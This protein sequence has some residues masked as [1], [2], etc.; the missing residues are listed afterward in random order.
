MME[1]NDNKDVIQ[2]EKNKLHIKY[3][4]AIAS[5]ISIG[6]IVLSLCNKDIFVA[7]VSFASTITSIV[8]S[9]IAIWMSISSERT[10][11][12]IK[13]KIWESTERLAKTTENVEI[14]NDRNESIMNTQLH[15]LND[16]KE[17]LEAIIHSVDTVGEQ[18]TI[19]QEKVNAAPSTP[20][21]TNNKTMTTE[22]KITLFQNLYTWAV[23][24]ATDSKKY[25]AWLLCEMTQKFIKN[26]KNSTPNVYR[27]AMHYLETINA[28]L[29]KW[30]KIIN[31]YWGALCMLSMASVFN[32]QN[33]VEKI[34]EKITPLLNNQP[35]KDTEDTSKSE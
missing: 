12:D 9:V 23:D 34:L 14:L 11:N 22:Q 28:D 17:K 26:Q 13:S 8:L 24:Y 6:S 16:V 25:R 2:N 20:R 15:E 35:P 30:G 21:T 27:D 29:N 10:T 1:K 19:M 3:L 32:D 5:V 4:I 33:A 31:S 18:V 7:Q